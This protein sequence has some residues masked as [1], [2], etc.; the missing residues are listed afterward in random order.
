MLFGGNGA[1]YYLRKG[2]RI[3]PRNLDFGGNLAGNAPYA[4]AI[5]LKIFLECI[6]AHRVTL[7]IKHS[8][9]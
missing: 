2:F 3:A 5:F 9:E 4:L 8:L 7:N 6:V 1:I